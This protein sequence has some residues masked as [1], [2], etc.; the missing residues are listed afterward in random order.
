MAKRLLRLAESWFW[1]L[2][3]Q[4]GFTCLSRFAWF[5]FIFAS[6]AEIWRSRLQHLD[7]FHSKFFFDFVVSFLWREVEVFHIFRCPRVV[8]H[9]KD[10]FVSCLPSRGGLLGH[11]S[12]RGCIESEGT[13]WLFFSCRHGRRISS[14]RCSVM[15]KG[16]VLY[17]LPH[18]NLIIF[19]SRIDRNQSVFER[20]KVTVTRKMF[21]VSVAL[22]HPLLALRA[23]VVY[24]VPPDRWAQKRRATGIHVVNLYGRCMS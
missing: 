16:L 13:C 18:G 9:L 21:S 1:E 14:Q 22:R 2:R 5:C 8:E 20:E 4:T 10:H 3:I 6:S 19:G 15:A 23:V 11:C 7:V 17:R 12:R 24:L